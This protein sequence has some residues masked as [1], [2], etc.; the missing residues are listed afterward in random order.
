M[1]MRGLAW[2]CHDSSLQ[3]VQ[4]SKATAGVRE[5]YRSQFELNSVFLTLQVRVQ[6]TKFMYKW[7]TFYFQTKCYRY[8]IRTKTIFLNN[9]IFF[10]ILVRPKEVEKT[11]ILRGAARSSQERSP[12]FP[13][14]KT[15]SYFKAVPSTVYSSTKR[16]ASL[17]IKVKYAGSLLKAVP[18]AGTRIQ[19]QRQGFAVIRH[20]V[21]FSLS[22]IAIID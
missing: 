22:H 1:C 19:S 17:E 2:L 4:W 13:S 12:S 18:G 8:K 5:H 7:K 16:D 14:S 3:F 6:I 10:L 11:T 21:S 15:N 9:Y 20:S